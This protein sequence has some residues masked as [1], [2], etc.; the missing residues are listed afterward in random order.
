[1]PLRSVANW[2]DRLSTRSLTVSFTARGNRPVA[3]PAPRAGR[4]H[5][6]DVGSGDEDYKNE[7][8]KRERARGRMIGSPLMHLP[9]FRKDG[10]LDDRITVTVGIVLHSVSGR[11]GTR[12]T[13]GPPIAR[14]CGTRDVAWKPFEV[15]LRT[16][17]KQHCTCEVLGGGGKGA[18]RYHWVSFKYPCI[19]QFKQCFVCGCKHAT[20]F[21]G[22]SIRE[23]HGPDVTDAGCRARQHTQ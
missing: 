21:R 6:V 11:R 15:L 8:W 23:T 13:Y 9:S 7:G 12:C 14:L 5:D 4:G 20:G 19:R 3:C 16:K 2:Y 10:V 18:C 22:S 1:M 17:T